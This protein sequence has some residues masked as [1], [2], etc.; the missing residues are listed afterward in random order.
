MNQSL[1]QMELRISKFLR[2]GVLVAGALMLVGWFGT[3]SFSGNPF[4]TFQVYG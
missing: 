2:Y 4:D 1:E 3:V